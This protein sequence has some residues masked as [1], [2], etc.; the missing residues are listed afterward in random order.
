MRQE[1]STDG[2]KLRRKENTTDS[3]AVLFLVR[4]GPLGS[5]A[6]SHRVTTSENLV[7]PRKALQS[8]AEPSQRPP[9]AAFENP[10][11]RRISSE[12][13]A[14]G[15]AS[16]MVTL[17]N[18]RI[19]QGCSCGFIFRKEISSEGDWERKGPSEITQKFRLRNWPISSADFPM[20][21]IEGTEHHFGPF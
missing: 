11:E 18:F 14:E 10:S 13:L 12:S 4:K 19:C 5:S 21:P 1:N 8:P 3:G 15:C 20:T 7:D 9:A 16:R 2:E 17:Q 6:G